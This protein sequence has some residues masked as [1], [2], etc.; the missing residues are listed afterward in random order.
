MGDFTGEGFEV[1]PSIYQDN[2][3]VKEV[4]EWPDVYLETKV[5]EYWQF[6]MREDLMP[7]ARQAAHR[8]L[9]HLGFE[10]DW[11]A[12]QYDLPKEPVATEVI[13]GNG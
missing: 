3:R 1:F 13:D 2:Q 6:L 11:R 9:E 8:I 5:T 12:G 4:A 10:I 7:R